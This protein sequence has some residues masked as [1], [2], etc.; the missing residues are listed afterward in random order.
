MSVQ[1]PASEAPGSYVIRAGAK[2]GSS[3]RGTRKKEGLGA[4]QLGFALMD[5]QEFAGL[6]REKEF[7]AGGKWVVGL[8]VYPGGGQYWGWGIY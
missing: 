3:P 4:L 5:Q 6:R 8:A 2:G 1:G 7:W